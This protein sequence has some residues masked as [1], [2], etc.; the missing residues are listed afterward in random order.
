[1]TIQKARELLGKEGEKLSDEQVLKTIET[2]RFFAN[3]FIDKFLEL[4]PKEM[5]RWKTKSE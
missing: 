3:I 5:E 4:T 1:M 2:A